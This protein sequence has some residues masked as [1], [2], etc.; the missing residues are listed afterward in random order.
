MSHPVWY[1]RYVDHRMI[2]RG[3]FIVLERYPVIRETPKGV[4]LALGFGDRRFV[5]RTARKRW[6]CPTED[7]A[8][9]SFKARKRRQCR[10]LRAQLKHAATALAQV[11]N[12]RV[13]EGGISW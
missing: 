7:E 1:Y 4:W 2:D 3:P 6:A 12:D 10:I 9:E 11:E 13:E 5:L 8:L